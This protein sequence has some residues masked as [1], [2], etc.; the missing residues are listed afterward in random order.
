MAVALAM[1]LLLA[2]GL[3]YTRIGL[4]IQ[5]S[6]TDPASC[7]PWDTTCRACSRRCSRWVQAW[8]RLP[9]WWVAARL[10][11]EPGM[12]AALGPVVFVVVIVGGLG[13]LGGAMPAALAIGLLQTLA[14][15]WDQRLGP[16]SLAQ[17]APLLPYLLLVLMLVLRPKGLLGRREG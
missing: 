10:V 11:T 17:V 5:A 9:G 15:V 6:L 16:V 12:A 8:R 2:L 7:R 1:W 14:V 3:R 13:S 4:V